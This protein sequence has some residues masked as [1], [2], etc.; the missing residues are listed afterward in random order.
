MRQ[1][2]IVPLIAG[3]TMCTTYKDCTYRYSTTYHAALYH[4][5][6]CAVPY[7][8]INEQNDIAISEQE[9]DMQKELALLYFVY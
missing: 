5:P 8:P 4:I 1:L 7:G 3:T 2:I 9:N 6:Y